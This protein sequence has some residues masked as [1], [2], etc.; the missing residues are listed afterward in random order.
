MCGTSPAA[1]RPREA[2]CEG[3]PGLALLCAAMASASPPT[4]R[5]PR[6][7]TP[8]TCRLEALPCRY[9]RLCVDHYRPNLRRPPTSD[10]DPS[11][12]AKK[13]AG[14]YVHPTI[15]GGI[16]HNLPQEAPRVLAQAVVDVDGSLA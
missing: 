13:F 2:P 4:P 15:S 9:G 5:L 6:W 1:I 8:R 11:A 10:P 7:R 14:T 12:Y 16:G 3:Y